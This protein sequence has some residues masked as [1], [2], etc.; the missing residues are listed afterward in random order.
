MRQRR[1]QRIQEVQPHLAVEGE[2]AGHQPSHAVGQRRPH[3]GKR[4]HASAHHQQMRHIPRTGNVTL[5]ARLSQAL[6]RSG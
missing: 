1:L 5:F 2:G 3:Q 4:P 6:L